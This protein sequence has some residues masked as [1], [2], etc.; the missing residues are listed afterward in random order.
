MQR[1][2]PF[3]GGRAPENFED[4]HG[5]NDGRILQPAMCGPME[6]DAELSCGTVEVLL[7]TPRSLIVHDV[8]EMLSLNLMCDAE[9]KRLGFLVWSGNSTSGQLV[10]SKIT[11][12][13]LAKHRRMKPRRREAVCRPVRHSKCGSD[14]HFVLEWVPWCVLF[15]LSVLQTMP[16]NMSCGTH[17]QIQLNHISV[18]RVAN[19]RTTA[20]R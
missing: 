9:G 11:T 18:A 12:K 16:Y 10:M 3:C 7:L 4:G 1:R 14:E 20:Q 19:Y 8:A 5:P 15:W 2:R 6:L 13:E 17:C